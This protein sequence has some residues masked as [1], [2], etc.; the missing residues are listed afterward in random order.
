MSCFLWDPA[1]QHKL[2]KRLFNVRPSSST[3]VHYWTDVESNSLFLHESDVCRN[4]IDSTYGW[5]Q[6]HVWLD[7]HYTGFSCTMWT[8]IV[9]RSVISRYSTL[10]VTGVHMPCACTLR[11]VGVLGVVIHRADAGRNVSRWWC[12][13][14]LQ[15]VTK[16]IN[17][18]PSVTPPRAT[19]KEEMATRCRCNVGPA[20]HTLA[21]H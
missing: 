12:R 21:Q 20:L 2:T 14:A 8:V 16:P 7:W 6:N 4:G 10:A 5:L 9:Y 17:H 3:P 11:R 18:A 19:T 15:T 1:F 13:Q